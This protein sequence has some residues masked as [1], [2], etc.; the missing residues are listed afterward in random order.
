MTTAKGVKVELVDEAGQTWDTT[1][2]KAVIGLSVREAIDLIENEMARK[3]K[4]PFKL[5]GRPVG[6]NS[7]RVLQIGDCLSIDP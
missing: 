5:N 6:R 7:K 2:R 1:V 4:P 3:S